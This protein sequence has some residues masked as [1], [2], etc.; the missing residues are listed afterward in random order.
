MKI[1]FNKKVKR[2]ISKNIMKTPI[3]LDAAKS[4]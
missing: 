2:R 4:N 1:K 3:P